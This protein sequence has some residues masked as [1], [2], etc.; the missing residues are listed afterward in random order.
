MEPHM[1]DEGYLGGLA[2]DGLYTPEIKPHS[3]QKLRRHNY[4]ARMFATGMKDRWTHRAY[5]GLYCGAGRAKRSDTGEII[6]T[7]TMSVL[8]LPDPFTH[9]VFVDEDPRCTD[10]LTQR[11]ASLPAAARAKIITGDVNLKTDEIK[12]ALPSYSKKETLLSFCFVDPFDVTLRFETI[13]SLA[14]YQMDFL[15]LLALG[16]D[17]RR[18]LRRHY[19]P[20]SDTRIAD[21][22]HCPTWRDEYRHSG[23]KITR[24]VLDK[25]DAAMVGLGYLSSNQAHPV[26]VSGGGVLLYYLVYYSKHQ[27][28]LTFW[29]STLKGVSGQGELELGL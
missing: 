25:F 23:K 16:F 29:K 4:V 18:N 7:T 24:F 15:V 6:E 17:L 21:L 26:K 27:L 19:E 1:N 13:R 2:D 14:T 10:A 8:R 22:I 11:S 12:R 5:V 28:G 9:Y 3:I 20:E